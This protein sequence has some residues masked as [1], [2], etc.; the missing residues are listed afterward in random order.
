MEKLPGLKEIEEAAERISGVASRTPLVESPALSRRTGKEV[1]LK[2][3][4][5]HQLVEAEVAEAGEKTVR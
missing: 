4:M 5:V 1:F 3:A 2:L